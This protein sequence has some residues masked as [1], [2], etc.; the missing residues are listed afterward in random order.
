M[1]NSKRQTVVSLLVR[2]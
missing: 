2:Y 1:L